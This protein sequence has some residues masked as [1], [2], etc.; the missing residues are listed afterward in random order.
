MPTT[1]T[2]MGAASPVLRAAL[3]TGARTGVLECLGKQKS[4]EIGAQEVNKSRDRMVYVKMALCLPMLNPELRAKHTDVKSC[5]SARSCSDCPVGRY[6]PMK[7]MLQCIGCS[8][9]L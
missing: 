4:A 6:A 8:R 1:G 2:R 3:P 5:G 9:G 7:G